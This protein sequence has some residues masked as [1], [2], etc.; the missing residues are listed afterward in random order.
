MQVRRY[1]FKLYPTKAQIVRLE[2]NLDLHRTLY[3]AALEERIEAYRKAGK[4]IG[5]YDQSAAVKECRAVYPEL[6]ECQ[7]MTLYATLQ[8]L[9]DAMKAF[10][11][12]A[13]AGAGAA[14]GFPRFKGKH[15]FDAVTYPADYA[16][17]FEATGNRFRFLG[18]SVT[19][20]GL[21]GKNDTL[22]WIKARGKFPAEGWLAR[23]AT[24]MRRDGGWWL[25]LAVQIPERRVAGL[26][27]GRVEFDL[28]DRFATVT[29]S[30]PMSGP[31]SGSA[32]EQITEPFRADADGS[33]AEA[34]GMVGGGRNEGRRGDAVAPAEAGGMAGE[35]RP[36]PIRI[37]PRSPAEA[38]GMAGDDRCVVADGGEDRHKAKSTIR[39]AEAGPDMSRVYAASRRLDVAKSEMDRSYK[40]GSCRWR[41]RRMA[42]SRAEAR[43]A[44][45]RSDALHVWTTRMVA[46]CR[47]LTVKAPASIQEATRSQKGTERRPGAVVATN[48]DLNRTVLGQAP[49]AAL[50]MLEYKAGEAGI[51]FTRE[52]DDRPVIA[53]GA[54]LAKAKKTERKARRL[55]KEKVA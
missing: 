1:T 13:K 34:G 35:D 25:S 11:R 52:I 17:A 43:V 28:L 16:F 23:T 6:A 45:A 48:A 4:T 7:C 51:Q 38:G 14:S 47:S 42:I 12:R 33:P 32:G 37:G 27:D 20:K 31:L 36:K 46:A 53:V 30:G 39:V 5:Y 8:R 40:R 21:P 2:R 41:A 55:M 19:K 9:D 24:V 29:L 10:F 26:A 3:N 49:A 22:G 15:Y 44:R 50:A 54:D 18:G